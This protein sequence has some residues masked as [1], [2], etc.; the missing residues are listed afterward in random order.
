M[1]N[2]KPMYHKISFKDGKFKVTPTDSDTWVGGF[3]YSALD[4]DITTVE[5]GKIQQGKI[6]LAKHLIEKKKIE[7]GKINRE[8]KELNKILEN[9]NKRS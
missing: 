3:A 5:S 1:S 8:L 4:G 6:K 7:F 2:T 9:E